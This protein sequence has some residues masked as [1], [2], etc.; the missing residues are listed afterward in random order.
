MFA[1]KSSNSASF[2]F[3]GEAPLNFFVNSECELLDLASKLPFE[4]T[5]LILL[6]INM[7]SLFEISSESFLL[8]CS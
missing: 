8:I 4:P 6:Y 7:F 2:S 1:S 5:S 3:S